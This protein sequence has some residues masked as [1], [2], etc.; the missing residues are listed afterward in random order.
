[1][2]VGGDENRP[3]HHTCSLAAW[4]IL[5]CRHMSKQRRS[6]SWRWWRIRSAKPLSLIPARSLRLLH[7]NRTSHSSQHTA[8]TTQSTVHKQCT[9][10]IHAFTMKKRK[11]FEN[12]NKNT[13]PDKSHPYDVAD[14]V[15]ASNSAPALAVPLECAPEVPLLLQR[16]LAQQVLPEVAQ[17]SHAPRMQQLQ[18]VEGRLLQSQLSTRRQHSIHLSR[19][20]GIKSK[21]IHTSRT[22]TTASA[23]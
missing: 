18:P 2:T 13:R 17:S 15:G 12:F 22:R 8:Q 20:K 9:R 16:G 6:S 19:P 23:K 21:H 11:T 5:A 1:M 10:Q 4:S 14:R 7:L 3:C